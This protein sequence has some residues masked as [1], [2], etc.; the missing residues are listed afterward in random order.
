LSIGSRICSTLPS[1]PASRRRPCASLALRRHQA[2]QR[3]STSKLS[4]MLGTHRDRGEP[5]G[6]SPP[7]PPYVRVRIRRFG[8]LS[9]PFP[10]REG[11]SPGL[12][13]RI[14]AMASVPAP[15]APSGF[16]LRSGRTGR[17][18]PVFCR[19]AS[20]RCVS[21]LHFHRSGLRRIAPPTTPSADFSV[22]VTHLATR[23]VRIPGRAGDLPR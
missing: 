2:G 8:G 23:S 14:A 1:D 11:R 16:T 15:P 13:S 21:P 7:T 20:A 4:I 6:P 10:L 12:S 19:M 17:A 18:I 22:A 5:R 9:G 3:T